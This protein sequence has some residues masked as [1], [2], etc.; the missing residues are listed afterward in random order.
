LKEKKSSDS[1][2]TKSSSIEP[3]M[4]VKQSAAYINVSEKTLR[5]LCKIGKI[6]YFQPDKKI[7]IRKH[8]LDAYVYGFGKRLTPTERKE[9]EELS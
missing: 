6:K 2:V 5:K 8:S 3:W 9:L 1:S 7:L 4:S